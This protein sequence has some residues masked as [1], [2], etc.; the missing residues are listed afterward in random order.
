[1]PSNCC[2]GMVVFTVIGGIPGNEIGVVIELV[3]TWGNEVKV[4][5]DWYDDV[6]P[7]GCGWIWEGN[8]VTGG[9]ANGFAG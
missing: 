5:G 7:G 8:W 3:W 6:A 9:W 2:G 1:M 4:G